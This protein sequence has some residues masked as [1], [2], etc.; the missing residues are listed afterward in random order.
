MGS[1][2]A[3]DRLRFDYAAPRPTTR[4]QLREV[5]RLVNEEVLRDSPVIKSVT[6]ID[7][8]RNAGR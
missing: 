1:L 7:E 8:P 3:P 2:V 6:S 5:E 4:A